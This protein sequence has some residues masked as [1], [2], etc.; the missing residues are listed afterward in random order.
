MED[1]YGGRG[2]G[3]S[4]MVE[5]EEWGEEGSGGVETM[6]GN[7]REIFDALHVIIS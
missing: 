2:W 3:V 4:R 6:A 1:Y 5:S 7:E